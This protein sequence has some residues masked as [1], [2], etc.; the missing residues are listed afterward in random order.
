MQWRNVTPY[1]TFGSLM[2]EI[3]SPNK[4]GSNLIEHGGTRDNPAIRV[5]G[6]WV[7]RKYNAWHDEDGSYHEELI[8]EESDIPTKP[9]GT[10]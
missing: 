5:K 6:E 4:Y 9:E 2:E 1:A 8:N 7:Y 3:L 10:D